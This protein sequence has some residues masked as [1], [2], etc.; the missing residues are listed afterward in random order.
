M[1]VQ[2]RISLVIG[3]VLVLAIGAFL[4][5]NATKDEGTTTAGPS[6]DSSML[7]RDDSHVLGEKGSSDVQLVEFLDFQC[8]SCKAMHPVIDDLREKYEGK[9]TFVLR[10]FP[11]PM[12]ENAQPAALAVEAAANQ[13]K[14]DEMAAAVFAS[15]EEWSGKS[16]SEAAAQFRGIAE[17]LG[18][19]L[20]Q[21]DADLTDP[22]TAARIKQ[23][24]AD[25]TKLGVQGTPTLFVGGRLLQLNSYDDI[26]VAIEKALSGDLDESTTIGSEPEGQTADA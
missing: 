26:E 1:N 11:L 12:H 21:Y 25:G 14:L 16:T 20:T 22:K 7:V 9:V 10:Q 4:V 6:V 18:L 23:D 8:P 3:T 17:K 15:Q 5:V 2:T 13:E 24:V 19:D